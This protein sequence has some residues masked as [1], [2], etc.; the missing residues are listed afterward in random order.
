MITRNKNIKVES[1]FRKNALTLVTGTAASQLIPIIATPLLT[2][3]YTPSEFGV[4]AF[5]LVSIT[6]F[7]IISTGRYELAI[8]LPKNQ[9]IAFYLVN[10]SIRRALIVFILIVPINYF[11][12]TTFSEKDVLEN[13]LL[14]LVP[15]SILLSALILIF[16]Q[17]NIRYE[18]F[19]LVNIIRI[20]QSSITTISA[21]LLGLISSSFLS[22]FIA[23]IAAKIF[24]VLLILKRK[25]KYKY[26]Y[27]NNKI[28]RKT[29][30]R[31]SNFSK[32]ETFSS[33]I[34]TLN[35]QLP[36][37][38]IPMFFSASAAGF[39]FL[40]FRVIMSP[41]SVFGVS[42][43]EAFKI[44]ATSDFRKNK[45][46]RKIFLKVLLTLLILGAIPT[47]LI[48]MFGKEIFSVLFGREWITA[49][50]YAQVLAPTALARL[51][52][53]PLSYMFHLREKSKLNSLIQ[54]LFLTLTIISLLAGYCYNDLSLLIILLSLS[55]CSFYLIQISISFRLTKE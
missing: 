44:K 51:I 24:V 31:Y 37:L 33:L 15:L 53:A 10:I 28:L 25:H 49:G 41:V 39:Y 12:I 7:S 46:C 3:L 8:F 1:S 40:V 26:A 22:L 45:N 19:S 47:L 38:V 5:I 6:I 4:F 34:S 21:L 11:I 2:R 18:N 17:L 42:I 27:C 9:R 35:F 29:Q 52:S 23:D 13:I 14:N 36:I 20:S 32:Y 30:K 48:M 55:G 50:F 16:I 54:T 43:Y